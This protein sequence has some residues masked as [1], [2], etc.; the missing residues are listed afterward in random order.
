MSICG[1]CWG[2]CL[3]Q[4][5]YQYFIVWERHSICRIKLGSLRVDILLRGCFPSQQ[6]GPY[7]KKNYLDLGLFYIMQHFNVFITFFLYLPLLQQKTFWVFFGFWDFLTN[8]SN[9]KMMQ[10]HEN[11]KIHKHV[12]KVCN[13]P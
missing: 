2:T 10:I 12:C 3:T 11:T 6:A 7:Y 13:G 8:I 4:L 5:N 1:L 9:E